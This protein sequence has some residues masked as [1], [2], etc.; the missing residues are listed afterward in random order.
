ME[1][2]EGLFGRDK[3]RDNVSGIIRSLSR[4]VIGCGCLL[5]LVI[6][7][8]IAALVGGII[9]FGES[10]VTVIIVAVMIIV[11]IASLIR[12]NL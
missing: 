1:F 7:G 11:A 2:L 6:V 3:G 12:S 4:W 8:T 9:S 5:V 10:A